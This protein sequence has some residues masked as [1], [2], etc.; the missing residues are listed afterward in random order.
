M[1]KDI[2][3][4]GHAGFLI[5][6]NNKN[7]YIDPFKISMASPQADY[8]L[9]THDH[10]DHLSEEDIEKIKSENTIVV[11]PK[12]S[13]RFSNSKT[14]SA[15]EEIKLDD[16]TLTATPAYNINK[17]F[18]PK[19]NGW[20]GYLL[21][22]GDKTVYHA[23]DTD[24]IPEMK[25]ITADIALLPVS[26]VYVMNPQEAALAAGDVKAKTA[27]PMHWGSIVGDD[28]DAEEFRRLAGC[29][30]LIPKKKVY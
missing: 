21:A 10:F 19:D 27:I 2:E 30:V 7:I 12:S 20:V 11:I 23:G 25:E 15:G 1:I 3:W 5:R 22:L 29:K 28:K 18:H 9:I 16:F 24:R 17:P 26:G 14:I 6:H 13:K 8:I 4:L